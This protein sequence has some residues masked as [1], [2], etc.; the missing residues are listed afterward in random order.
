MSAAAPPAGSAPRL[1]EANW[2]WQAH[3]KSKIRLIVDGRDGEVSR[4]RVRQSGVILQHRTE[5]PAASGC[6]DPRL[7]ASKTSRPA[8]LRKKIAGARPLRI[9][10]F[11]LPV[12]H[13]AGYFKHVLA[14]LQ[15]VCKK[16][17]EALLKPEERAKHLA[18]RKG[19]APE[20]GAST[21]A[22]LERCK[23][24]TRCPH[25]GARNGPVRE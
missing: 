21:S 1:V 11:A 14:L 10:K 7:D 13:H 25:C 3:Q 5:G 24:A 22:V 20:A 2:W 17:S 4:V 16:C 19:R 18:M 23:A 9:V 6:L 8:R 12:F 15:C